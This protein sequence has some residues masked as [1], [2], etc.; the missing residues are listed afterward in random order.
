[1]EGELR[2]GLACQK[3]LVAD[4]HLDLHAPDDRHPNRAGAYLAACVFYG[5]LY[6]RS[7]EGLPGRI[8]GLT[9]TE[10]YRLQAIAW[11]VVQGSSGRAKD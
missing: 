9:D 6:G 8:G 2:A 3:A 1:V 11:Q 4:N 5:T 7:P 10:A